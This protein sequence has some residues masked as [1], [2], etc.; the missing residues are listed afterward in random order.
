LL[1]ACSEEYEINTTT[2]NPKIVVNG[3]IT[4]TNGPYYVRLT[5]S[6]CQTPPSNYSTHYDDAEPIQ[7][8]LVIITDDI[9]TVDTL[10]PLLS[11]SLRFEYNKGYFIIIHSDTILVSDFQYYE[12]G[13]FYRTNI[14]NGVP[15]RTY[16][17]YINN[18]GNEYFAEAYMPHV[19]EI[20]SL[21]YVKKISE[22][23]GREYYIP[24]LYFSEPQNVKN[25]YLIRLCEVGLCNNLY[26]ANRNWEF[27][28]L[29]DEFLEPYVNGLN[30]DDG[31][32]PDG[33]DYYIFSLWYPLRVSLYSLT[34]EA[35]EFYKVLLS[36]FEN[37][38]GTFKPSPASPPSN[39]SNGALGIF[40]ASA[41]DTMSI[42]SSEL[43]Q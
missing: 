22:K 25:Y 35:Y 4:S 43:R 3:L 20:D 11:D 13:G 5:K 14:I 12:K 34:Y 37:D 41:V 1:G 38:G 16:N 36:Q 31:A 8:A 28:V 10:T 42:K 26:A 17:L 32:S 21:S 40:R 9:G 33:R 39:I 18:N 30:V 7:D 23:D 19:P 15:G 24:L 29:S 6:I 27:S 2:F